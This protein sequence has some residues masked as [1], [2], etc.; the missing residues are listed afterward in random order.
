MRWRGWWREGREEKKLTADGRGWT[1]M[2]EEKTKGGNMRKFWK[3]RI[4]V[5]RETG[6]EDRELE[7]ALAMNA[8]YPTYMGIMELG[9]RVEGAMM[10]EA[11]D[12]TP[13]ERLRNLARIEGVRELLAHFVDWTTRLE[14]RIKAEE[15]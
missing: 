6:M 10:A 1:R 5:V 8:Q 15:K 9:S 3:R 13:E 2:K 14:R 4:V 11:L 7:Q 12:G